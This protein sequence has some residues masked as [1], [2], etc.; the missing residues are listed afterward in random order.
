MRL[1]NFEVM[2]RAVVEVDG[3]GSAVRL[4]NTLSSFRYTGLYRVQ[5]GLLV[6]RALW[7]RQ[8]QQLTQGD[9][10]PLE[11]SFCNYMVHSGQGLSVVDS[12]TDP[13]LAGHPR[14]MEFRSYCGAPL[15]D[16][17]GHVVGSFCHFDVEPEHVKADDLYYVAIG[18]AVLQELMPGISDL[19]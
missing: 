6:C 7:D 16:R 8:M 13:R 19:P 14:Q 3:I 15:L 11:Q 18:A 17:H 12:L 10:V 9:A 1:K 5:G 2:L 4:A